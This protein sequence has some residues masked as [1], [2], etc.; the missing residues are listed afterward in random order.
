MAEYYDILVK[1]NSRIIEAYASMITGSKSQHMPEGVEHRVESDSDMISHSF[2][3]DHVSKVHDHLI[4]S[5]Y[6]QEGPSSVYGPAT[7]TR[8]VHPETKKVV[9]LGKNRKTA[10]LDVHKG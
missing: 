3:P 6:K 2:H 7:E 1:A 5:G 4:G 10:W 8:Y 9:Y